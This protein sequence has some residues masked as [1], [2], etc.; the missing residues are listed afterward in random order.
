[1]SKLGSIITST[2]P[3]ATVLTL[4]HAREARVSAS[5]PSAG[6][7]REKSGAGRWWQRIPKARLCRASTRPSACCST[8]VGPEHPPEEKPRPSH[9]HRRRFGSRSRVCARRVAQRRQ[10]CVAMAL[11]ESVAHHR[12]PGHAESGGAA[13][14]VSAALPGPVRGVRGPWLLC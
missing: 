7:P 14:R 8:P 11:D 10:R 1:M 3:V 6:V 5:H 2:L 9:N 13:L 4:S 12:S